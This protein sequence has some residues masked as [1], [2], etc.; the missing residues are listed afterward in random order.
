VRLIFQNGISKPR[1]GGRRKPVLAFTQEGVAML[2]SVLR[3]ERA[4]RVNIEIMRANFFAR[5]ARKNGGGG[6]IRTHGRLAPSPVFKTGALDR[7]ATP[8]ANSAHYRHS[9]RRSNPP[10]MGS[11]RHG[12]LKSLR[13]TRNARN[14]YF[15]PAFAFFAYFVVQIPLPV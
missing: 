3:S 5:A 2:S 1:Q 7:S 8:P 4:V 14:G 11:S 6:E 10:Q 15:L 12:Q 9:F 13:N